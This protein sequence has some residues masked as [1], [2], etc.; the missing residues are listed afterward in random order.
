MSR[1]RVRRAALAVAKYEEVYLHAYDEMA[2]ARAGI[3]R[4][5]AFYNDERSHQAL[6]Y[7]TP[8]AFYDRAMN[9][10]AA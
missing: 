10:A 1:Q 5:L 8:A 2:S 6:G 3:T 4:Y 7:Q 9:K